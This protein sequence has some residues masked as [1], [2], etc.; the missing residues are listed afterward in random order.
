M[1]YEYSNQSGQSAQRFGR[2]AAFLSAFSAVEPQ[3]PGALSSNCR[4][5]R[6]DIDWSAWRGAGFAFMPQAYVDQFG[7]AAAS[8]VHAPG[9]AGFFAPATFTRP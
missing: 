4:A 8:A 2:S 9:A 7:G 6:H 1:E 3:L 5:D